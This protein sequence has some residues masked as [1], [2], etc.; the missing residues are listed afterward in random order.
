[1]PEPELVHLS[2]G[3]EYED[4]SVADGLQRAPS[5]HVPGQ[6]NAGK[7]RV[8]MAAIPDREGGDFLNFGLDQRRGEAHER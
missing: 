4:R 6:S 8:G 1:V 7:I 2:G 5:A 3:C